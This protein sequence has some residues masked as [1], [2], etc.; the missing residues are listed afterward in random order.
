H[1]AVTRQRRDATPAG[2]WRSEQR[3]S[4]GEA[5]EA[6]CTAP[7]ICSGEASIKGA[8]RPGM[9]ADL[10][11]LSADPFTCPPEDLHVITA[12]LTMVGGVVVWERK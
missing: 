7:A 1:A 12:E 8:L 11:V 6:Y 2:G 4:V 5:L 3:L 9:L 10:A